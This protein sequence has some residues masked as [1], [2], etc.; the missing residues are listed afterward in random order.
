MDK[1]IT[2]SQDDHKLYETD[3][4][5]LISLYMQQAANH[6][7]LKAEEEVDL[8]QRMEQGH[9]ARQEL[10]GG[11]VDSLRRNE[12]TKLIEA[13]WQARECMIRANSRLVISIAKKYSGRGMPFLDLIQEG[14]IG[15]LRAIKKF[16]YRRGIKFS[17]YATWW[18]RQAVTR[19]IADQS[20][21]IRVPA[22]M[23]DRISKMFRIQH[24]LTQDLQRE[25]LIGELAEAL[26]VSPSKIKTMLRI[27][28]YPV[29]LDQRISNE[30]D[31]ELG[32]LIENEEAP[33]P[34]LTATI[35]LLKEHVE[36]ILSLLP[37]REA[38]V[39]KLRYGLSDGQPY[40]LSEV[41][42]KFG[43]SRERIRQIEA[44][45]FQRLRRSMK[46]HKLRS[47]IAYT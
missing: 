3:V 17:T 30:G 31:T 41:G 10:S 39:L 25:P 1:L 45:A 18:I 7:L 36:E 40:T 27:A 4:D 35:T 38:R 9:L 14:N 6:K 22:H 34:D 21:T 12:L 37:P 13:G 2:A 32:D 23:F 42:Q 24:Q 8:A 44:N 15:L 29:S 20:R 16:D 11:D 28:R 47:F 19:A 26:D 43:L 33:D 46:A 5:D